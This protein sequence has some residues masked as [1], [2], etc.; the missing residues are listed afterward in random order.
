MFKKLTLGN[1]RYYLIVGNIITYFEKPY[2]SQALDWLFLP[3]AFF[4]GLLSGLRDGHGTGRAAE[5]AADAHDDTTSIDEVAGQISDD[6][7]DND[8]D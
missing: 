6:G 4:H 2:K 3:L 8:D 5:T 1:A 7:E